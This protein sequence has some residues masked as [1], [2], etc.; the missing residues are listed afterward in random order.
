MRIAHISD[1]HYTHIT[2]NP[3]RLF[4]KRFLG[5]LNWLFIRRKELSE[6]QADSLVD[7]L[8]ELNVDY[9]FFGGDFST[10]S[11]PEEFQK[12]KAFVSRI[13][14]PWF[15]I[16]GNHDR[17]T[18]KSCKK[19]SFYRYFSNP[20]KKIKTP[21]DFFRLQE[22]RIETYPLKE[23][24]HLIALDTTLATPLSSSKGLFS[25][26][27]EGYLKEVLAILPKKDSVILFNHYPF[28]KDLTERRSLKRREALE[29]ILK[30]NP[31]IKLYLH[32]HTHRQIVADLQNANLP[33]V[34]DSGSCTHLK[35]GSWNLIDIEEN[36]CKVRRYRFDQTWKEQDTQEFSWTRAYL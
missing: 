30:E 29:A 12:A 22:H 10:T 18:K 35:H 5:N 15:A 3:F 6:K 32:G 13:K 14:I 28:L 23:G 4:S 16:P 2:W 20:Q 7:L 21:T 25:E 19:K 27:L 9:V 31:Q 36:G 8:E 24:W 1:F 34:L 26:K 33:L 17:Y 11:L